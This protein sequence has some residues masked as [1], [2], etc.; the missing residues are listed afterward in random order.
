MQ[1]AKWGAGP[2]FFS[3]V[4]ADVRRRIHLWPSHLVLV[5]VVR[6]CFGLRTFFVRYDS[7]MRNIECG[8][9]SR[10]RYSH[11]SDQF[12]D[13]RS[14]HGQI[15][16]AAKSTVRRNRNQRSV[17][18]HVRSACCRFEADVDVRAPAEPSR[19]RGAR[20]AGL[21][22]AATRPALQPTPLT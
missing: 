22:C 17:D 19:L 10:H 9:G 21:P 11:P 20:A 12:P 3:F 13:L 14:V 15:S 6:I 8:M 7:E 2:N 4:G 5:S 18:I 16:I 1:N